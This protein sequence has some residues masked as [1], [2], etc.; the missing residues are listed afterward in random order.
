MIWSERP[1][2]KEI[3]AF[4]RVA[5]IL[6]DGTSTARRLIVLNLFSSQC[7]CVM[8]WLCGAKFLSDCLPLS[9]ELKCPHKLWTY[10]PQTRHLISRHTAS[11]SF[12]S[13]RPILHEPNFRR[14]KPGNP[15]DGE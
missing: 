14:W 13:A 1:L 10:D 3:F 8:D 6:R 11:F 15:H 5:R 12:A 9:G 4:R 2:T 7:R